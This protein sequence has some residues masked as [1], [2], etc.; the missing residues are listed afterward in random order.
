M[1]KAAIKFVFHADKAIRFAYVSLV[2]ILATFALLTYQELQRQRS[3]PVILPHYAFYI[4]DNPEKASVV[5]AMGTWYVTDGPAAA[6]N[7]QT[8]T[9]E[10][11]K[12]RLECV[13]STAAVALNENRLLDSTPAVFEVA[14]WT[15]EEVV[16]TPENG[17][18]TT[19]YISL[20][21]VNRLARSVIVAIPGAE[22]CKEQPRTL[23]LGGVRLR[24]G[25]LSSVK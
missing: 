12:A 24:A 10:C 16:T 2:A 9:I 13:E 3:I 4:I 11:R 8:T 1:E 23:K 7:L 5:Q 21:L 6:D 22:P 17:K 20:D 18:C 25:V 14:R 15:D 19:R